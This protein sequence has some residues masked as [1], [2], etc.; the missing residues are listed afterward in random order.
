MAAEQARGEGP[1][2]KRKREGGQAAEKGK[3]PDIMAMK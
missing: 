2:T 3:P 1:A